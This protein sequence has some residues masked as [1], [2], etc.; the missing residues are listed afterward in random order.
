MQFRG[1]SQQVSE[2]SGAIAVGL[3][4]V[5]FRQG[6]S[7]SLPAAVVAD[8]DLDWSVCGS[9]VLT[10]SVFR[11]YRASLH[12]SGG[13]FDSTRPFALDLSYLRRI[14]ASQIVE[15]SIDEIRRLRAPDNDTLTRWQESLATL[16]PDVSLG[17]RL[18]GV[19]DPL[20]AVVFYFDS[21]RLGEIR[22]PQFAEAFAAIWLDPQTRSPELRAK[23]LGAEG[24]Q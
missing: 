14:P 6:P 11:I 3:G 10:W 21:R 15:R 2:L 7:D 19:F 5:D 13:Q 24:G 16:M 22:D 18:V 1:R 17:S 8:F 4:A 9:G 12:V 23:L 20:G